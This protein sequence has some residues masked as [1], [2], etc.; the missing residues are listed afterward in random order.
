MSPD[1]SASPAAVP[2]SNHANPQTLDLYA[3]ALGNP[4]TSADPDGHWCFLGRFGTTSPP[5]QPAKSAD[6]THPYNQLSFLEAEFGAGLVFMRAV[7]A[8]V[9]TL[10]AA[11]ARAHPKIALGALQALTLASAFFDDGASD[12]ALPGEEALGAEAEAGGAGGAAAEGAANAG[13]IVAEDGTEISDITEHG[14][15]RAIGDGARRAG[16]TPHAILDAL[17]N[18]ERITQGVDSEGRPFNVFYGRD[19][20]VI[21]NPETGRIVPVNPL[22]AA[23]A[24]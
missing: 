24:H 20:R 21:V 15:D 9:G 16:T 12:L 23:G 13:T 17:R 2:Y 10:G 8:Q 5:R 3:Y 1:W 4:A 14:V 7:R 19:A 22:T 18:P 6:P 11:E